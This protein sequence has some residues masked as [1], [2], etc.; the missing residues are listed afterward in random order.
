[1]KDIFK[2][3]SELHLQLS[4]KYLL[5]SQNQ[6]NISGEEIAAQREASSP[7]VV[8][9]PTKK[10]AAKLDK[11]LTP[12]SDLDS[13]DQL[14]VDDRDLPEA[15]K[16][17]VQ[18]VALPPVSQLDEDEAEE[19]EYYTVNDILQKISSMRKL[20]AEKG[21]D[22]LNKAFSAA[23]LAYLKKHKADRKDLITQER[24]PEILEALKSFQENELCQILNSTVA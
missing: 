24:V 12:K 23:M 3:I 14:A 9:S 8:K 10:K 11:D 19:T 21:D 1:M 16:K 18:K 20:V 4:E 13:S 15:T 5:L 7:P 17:P 6:S 2:D 22:D